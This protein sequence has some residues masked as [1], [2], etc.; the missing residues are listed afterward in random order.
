MPPSTVIMAMPDGPGSWCAN[1][2]VWA[3]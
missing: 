3:G 2:G 1:P